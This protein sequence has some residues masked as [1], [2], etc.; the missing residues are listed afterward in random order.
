MW[1]SEKKANLLFYKGVAPKLAAHGE[2]GGTTGAP[3][4]GIRP[5]HLTELPHEMFKEILLA[6]DTGDVDMACDTAEAWCRV[7]TNVRGACADAG[8]WTQLTKRVFGVEREAG[9][10]DVA[11]HRAFFREL[12]A[13]F[14][15]ILSAINASDGAKAWN[16][17]DAWHKKHESA[18]GDLWTLLTQRVF[19]VDPDGATTPFEV[20][21]D[22]ET[23]PREFFK[24]LC[25][26]VN[27]YRSRVRNLRWHVEDAS[28][29]AFLLAAVRGD[30]TNLRKASPELKNDKEVVL[31]AVKQN[32]SALE[33]ASEELQGNRDVVLA[34]KR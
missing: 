18:R 9:S 22:G 8:L 25:V 1:S 28:N 20:E 15:T 7:D 3:G 21:P 33:W 24:E 11:T 30:G 5:L 26:I 4:A 31:A 32:G 19:E 13:L 2:R 34:A 16:A 14:K 17:A 27:D 23:T 6:V 12:C 10:T 29:R